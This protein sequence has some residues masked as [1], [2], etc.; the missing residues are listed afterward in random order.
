MVS[1]VDIYTT[2]NITANTSAT[3][4]ITKNNAIEELQK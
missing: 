1:T 3:T 4:T 2:S